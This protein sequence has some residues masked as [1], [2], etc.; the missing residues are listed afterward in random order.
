MSLFFAYF[1]KLCFPG[2]LSWLLP[3]FRTLSTPLTVNTIYILMT[4]EP[5]SPFNN[6]LWDSFSW[7]LLLGHLCLILPNSYW[8]LKMSKKKMN[9]YL[10]L[11]LCPCLSSYFPSWILSHPHLLS[12]SPLSKQQQQEKQPGKSGTSSTPAFS[13]PTFTQHTHTSINMQLL[14]NSVDS[15]PEISFESISSISS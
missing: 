13:P 7:V 10:T 12:Q 1:L 15:V 4:L 9:Y 5:V 6:P 11:F 14:A 8:K 2:L 3:S